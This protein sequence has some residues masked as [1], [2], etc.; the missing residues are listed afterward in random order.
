MHTSKSATSE[1]FTHFSATPPHPLRRAFDLQK[2]LKHGGRARRDAE[3]DLR[4]GAPAE[5]PPANVDKSDS[6][7]GKI[8][9]KAAPEKDKGKAKAAPGKDKG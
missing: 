8:K 2:R 4:N 1:L 5:E 3:P 7:K 6:D 9:A